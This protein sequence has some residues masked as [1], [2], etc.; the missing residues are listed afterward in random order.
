MAEPLRS[1]RA[2]KDAESRTATLTWELIERVLSSPTLCRIYLWGKAGVGKTY[3]AYHKGRIE[4]GCYAITLTQEMPASELRGHYLPK[5][6]RFEWHDGPV[7]R[8]MRE[9]ARLVI[10]EILHASDDV[11][12]FLYPILEFEETAR[13]TLPTGE[14][15][16]PAA[17]FNTVMTDNAAPDELPAPLRDRFDAV[18]EINEPHPEAL[19]LLPEALREVAGRGFALED[20]RRVS[21]RGWLGIARLEAEFGLADA[22]T[23]VFGAERGSQIYDAILLARGC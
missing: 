17:G 21:I 8:A 22:C 10:N 6:D 2:K 3:C 16:T 1:K 18:L 9:G 15:V 7:I 20:D 23:I 4:R 13:I 19:A 11:L 14:T 12:S 5:G